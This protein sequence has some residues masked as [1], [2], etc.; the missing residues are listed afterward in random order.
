MVIKK[1]VLAATVVVACNIFLAVGP[2]Q[3]QYPYEN[4]NSSDLGILG[5]G[6]AVF[7]AGYWLESSAGNAQATTGTTTDLNQ[8]YDSATINFFD[9]S[10][11]NNW[12]PASADLSDVFMYSSAVAPLSL[13]LSDMGS[14]Q[15]LTLTA[16]H[17]ETLLLNGGVTYLMK[18]MF[19]RPRPFL[20]H[21]DHGISSRLRSSHTARLSFPSGHTS[22]SFSSL[23]FLA[24]VFSTLYPDSDARPYVW[25]GCLA[26]AGTTG[27]LRYRAGFHYPT[28]IIAGA[29]LG[30]FVGWLVPTLHEVQARNAM[31]SKSITPP[32]A[33]GFSIAF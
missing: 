22:T 21:Q 13:T 6:V 11:T 14:R 23:V 19:R 31:S 30:S 18:N 26:V 2:I 27:Y 12:S 28:D 17:L 10:A 5:T 3:A 29:V 15:P 7:S 25:G 20:Y 33:L 8:A 4:T 32:V 24:K 1:V 16:M 9:R